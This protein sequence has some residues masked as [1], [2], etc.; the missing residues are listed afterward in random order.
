MTQPL[1]SPRPPAPP[2]AP[3]DPTSTHRTSIAVGVAAREKLRRWSADDGRTMMEL[4]DEAL[5]LLA[6]KRGQGAPRPPRRQQLSPSARKPAVFEGRTFRSQTE[7][8]RHLAPIIG[9]S[10]EACQHALRLHG[11]VAKVIDLYQTTRPARPT[12]IPLAFDGRVYRS[13]HELARHLGRLTGRSFASCKNALRRFDDD[14]RRVLDNFLH[15][16]S[17]RGS[18]SDLARQLAGDTGRSFHTC[19]SALK[20]HHDDVTAVMEP[21]RQSEMR[22]R[23]T[24]PGGG[25]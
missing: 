9:R 17:A 8:A 23:A 18:R 24:C 15:P 13:R 16:R 6:E 12:P 21:W 3:D 14:P 4:V 10:V 1:L 11:D 2:P 20:R 22:G 7:L 5:A 19:Y 25:E